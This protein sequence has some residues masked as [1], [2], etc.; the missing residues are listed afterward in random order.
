MMNSS[1]SGTGYTSTWGKNDNLGDAALS[2]DCV[3]FEANNDTGLLFSQSNRDISAQDDGCKL[4]LGLGPTPTSYRADY[5]SEV[6]KSKESATKFS[7]SLASGADS[8]MLKLKLGIPIVDEGSTSAKRM[9]GGHMPS[10]LFAPRAEYSNIQRETRD[11]LDIGSDGTTRHHHQFSPRLSATITTTDSSF[12][13][14]ISDQQ[15]S[16]H[17][18]HPKKCRFKGCSKGAR[19]ASGLC[20]AHGGGQRCQKPGCNSG[21]ESRTAYCLSLIHI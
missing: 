9:S 14:V 3:G 17:Y 4:V 13:G 19:G 12:G 7:Q 18:H 16:H 15:R 8:G 2:L 6:T 10:L 20:I 21:A 1:V 5:P 11:L